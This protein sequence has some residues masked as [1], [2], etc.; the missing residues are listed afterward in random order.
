MCVQFVLRG[1]GEPGKKEVAAID[2]RFNAY[3]GVQKEDGTWWT[4]YGSLYA[5]DLK[6][7][8]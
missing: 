8:R 3:G 5:T 7:A 4:K 2:F 1:D 6:D